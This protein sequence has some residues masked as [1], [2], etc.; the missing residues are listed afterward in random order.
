MWEWLSDWDKFW[1]AASYAAIGSLIYLGAIMTASVVR[2][3]GIL[4]SA[5]M[6]YMGKMFVGRRRFMQGNA[7]DIINVTINTTVGGVLS[8][9]TQVA[10]QLITEVYS[11]PYH[12]YML[13]AAAKRC[14]I[15]DPIVKFTINGDGRNGGRSVDPY[16]VTYDPLISMVA[17]RC[18]N[19]NSIDLALG[20]PMVEHRFVIA[21]T[22]EKACDVRSQ[23][24]R[25]M[26]LNE[27]ELLNFPTELATVEREEHKTRFDTLKAIAAQYKTNPERFGLVKVWRPKE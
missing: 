23:H 27:V 10:D 3:G 20:V 7:A 8:I 11:N 18:T 12:V 25:A 26:M 4:S 19:N 17:E 5:G 22:F 13:R 2:S 24:F 15:E 1:D 9:D 14:T 6:L 21:L 16:R